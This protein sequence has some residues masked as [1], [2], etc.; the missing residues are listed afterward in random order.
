MT[1]Q[2]WKALH[3]KAAAMAMDEYAKEASNLIRLTKQEVEDVL[4]E[5]AV[6]MQKLT[7]LMA[8]IKSTA[9]T[10]AQKAD[11]VRKIS[12]FAEVIVALLGRLG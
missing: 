4:S 11:A 6:D 12:G 10:N 5:A 1:E 2:E 9:K 8:V 3:S 7:E